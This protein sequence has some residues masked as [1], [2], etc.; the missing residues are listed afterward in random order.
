[1]FDVS[2]GFFYSFSATLIILIMLNLSW[3]L[4]RPI[5]RWAKCQV[6]QLLHGDQG[7]SNAGTERDGAAE[8]RLLELEV[9]KDKLVASKQHDWLKDVENVV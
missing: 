7:T 6:N 5:A 9:V 3:G 4:L 8:D 1:L 2:A